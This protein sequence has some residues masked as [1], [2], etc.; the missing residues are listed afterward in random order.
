MEPPP[1]KSRIPELDGIRGVAILSVLCFHYISMEGLA[2]PGSI[3]DRLQRLVILGGTGVDLFFVLSGFLIGGILLDAKDSPR[4]FATFYTR[5]FFRIFP[6]YYLWITAYI[7]V[8]L[9]GGKRLLALSHSGIA[10]PLNFDVYSHYLFI[11]NFF[12]DRFHHLAGAWFDH[13]WSLAVEEQ[14]YLV[15]PLLVWL[16][17][18]RALKIF[19]I[20]I[21]VTQPLLRIL[22]LKMGWVGAGLIGQLS[23]TRADVLAFGV[24]VAVYWREES[25]R[26]WLQH[27]P[28]AILAALAALFVGFAAFWKWSP[29]MRAFAMEAAGYSTIALFYTTLLVAALCMP[30]GAIAK[31][32]RWNVLRQLGAV[33]YC[34][35]LIHLVVDVA[36]HAVIL[37]ATPKTSNLRGAAVT[38]FAAALTFAI[39]KV[40]WVVFER[41]LLRLGHTFRY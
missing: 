32:A 3:A 16:F 38:L 21:V 17:S 18:R 22:L 35:Y 11:Q 20:A 27:N 36:C 30:N 41:P 15:I 29:Y 9:F 25:V 2:S 6:V 19:L 34:M 8:A 33:S 39:A 37:H 1:N 12:L 24:L 5:R 10:P 4:F 13:T 28:R 40:S 26:T 7:F 14:F 23:V 31:V